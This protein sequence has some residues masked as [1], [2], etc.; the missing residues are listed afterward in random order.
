MLTGESAHQLDERSRVAIPKQLRSV[1]E[2][3]GFIT[4]GWHG[5]LF[6]LPW[7]RWEGI[8][9]K[10]NDLRLT[11]TDGYL[12][13]RFFSSGEEVWADPQGRIILPASLRKYA[14]IEKDVVVMGGLDCLEIWA[15]DRW[16]AFQQEQFEPEAIMKKAASLGI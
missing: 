3:G 1:V 16:E 11:D 12:V 5:C 8:A 14:G 13:R 7:Q 2:R 9:Q 6:L 4:R 10:L 15:K